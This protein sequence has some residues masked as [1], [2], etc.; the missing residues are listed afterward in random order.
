MT[1]GAGD[2]M[3]VTADVAGNLGIIHTA[4]RNG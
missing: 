4:G 1:Y 3:V 2:V